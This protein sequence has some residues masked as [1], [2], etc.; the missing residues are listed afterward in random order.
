MSRPGCRDRTSLWASCFMARRVQ[1]TIDLLRARATIRARCRAHMTMIV[2]RDNNPPKFS[3]NAEAALVHLLGPARGGFMSAT[4]AMGRRLPHLACASVR[5]YCRYTRRGSP[6]SF[7]ASIR[8]NSK[9]VLAGKSVL[10][11]LLPAHRKGKLWTCLPNVLRIF[12]QRPRTIS[13]GSFGRGVPARLRG[14][15]GE[16]EFAAAEERPLGKLCATGHETS[17]AAEC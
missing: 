17:P 8:R 14:T 10:D 7:A 3:P 5:L 11:H 16:D 6:M 9:N 4:A 15:G 12:R 13:S 2:A 1:G